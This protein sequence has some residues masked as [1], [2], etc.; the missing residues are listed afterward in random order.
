MAY[1]NS[2]RFALILVGPVTADTASFDHIGGLV[3]VESEMLRGQLLA[4]FLIRDWITAGRSVYNNIGNIASASSLL[5]FMLPAIQL[6]LGANGIQSL[7][8]KPRYLL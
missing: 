8:W 2:Y 5:V 1:G 7:C 4:N 6:Y 3:L